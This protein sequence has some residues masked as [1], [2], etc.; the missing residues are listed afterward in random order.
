MK[1]VRYFLNLFF[2]FLMRLCNETVTIELKNGSIV[3]GT[4]VGIYYIKFIFFELYL[5][6]INI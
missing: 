1:L 6:R 5:I 3:K 4:I 2:R